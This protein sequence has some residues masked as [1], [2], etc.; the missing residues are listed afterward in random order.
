MSAIKQAVW[1]RREELRKCSC[2]SKVL[3]E[4]ERAHR[5]ADRLSD[6]LVIINDRDQRFFEQHG[7]EPTYTFT[8]AALRTE[9]S[10]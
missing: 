7:L 5:S 8:Q 2:R 4:A 9:R 1:S 6:S 10:R 3:G